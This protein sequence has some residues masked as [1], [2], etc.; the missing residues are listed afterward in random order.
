M[1]DI[2]SIAAGIWIGLAG[3]VMAQSTAENPVVVELYTSQG[4]SSCPP[5]DK[6]LQGLAKRDDVIALALHV[7]YWD[8]IGWKDSFADP[9]RLQRLEQDHVRM[10]GLVAFVCLRHNTTKHN[11]SFELRQV[12]FRRLPRFAQSEDRESRQRA[13]RFVFD[14]DLGL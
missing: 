14:E 13:S 5:A 11:L 6:V 3:T 1:R 4:C 2:I 10:L 12:F 8:Y 9:I 7:D